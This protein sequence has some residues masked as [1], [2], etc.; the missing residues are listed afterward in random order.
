MKT[1]PFVHVA[2]DKAPTLLELN[3]KGRMIAEEARAEMDVKH[4]EV[5]KAVAKAFGR[6]KKMKLGIP[7]GS[8]QAA[9]LQKDADTAKA[10]KDQKGS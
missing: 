10:K 7:E 1:N 9:Q 5:S 4:E 3:N 2:P 8:P 6:E